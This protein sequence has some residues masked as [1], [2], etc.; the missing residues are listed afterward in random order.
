[1]STIAKAG[2]HTDAVVV[3]LEAA[4][5][6]VFDAGPPPQRAPEGVEKTWG[7]VPSQVPGQSDF[8]PYVI[9]YPLPGGFF[10]GPLGCPDDDAEMIWQVTCVAETRRRCQYISDQATVAL[11]GQTLAVAGRS[12]CRL[13]LDMDGGVRRDDTVQPPVFISTPRFRATS[14]P[15]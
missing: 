15:A 10:D 1:M 3:A 2:E 7:W 11:V 5:L 8:R 4:D 9:L 12:I 14:T 6:Q 13:Q